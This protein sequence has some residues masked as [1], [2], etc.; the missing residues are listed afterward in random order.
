MMLFHCSFAAARR[1]GANG[2]CLPRYRYRL[3]SWVTTRGFLSRTPSRSNDG[4]VLKIVP[5][6]PKDFVPPV[7]QPAF[8]A[9]QGSKPPE[10]GI[11]MDGYPMQTLEDGC[12]EV[13]ELRR[14]QTMAS[15][16]AQPINSKTQNATAVQYQ[17]SGDGLLLN[18]LQNCCHGSFVFLVFVLADSLVNLLA[19]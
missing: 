11:F 15:R 8:G 10:V 7:P 14:Y 12:G 1:F 13:D 9:F 4:A 5:Q 6:S 2:N 18:Q 19:T 3:Q 16:P 17:M